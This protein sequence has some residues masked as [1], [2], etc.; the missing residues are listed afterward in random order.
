[1][2]KLFGQV[3]HVAELE[4]NPFA[5]GGQAILHRAISP[6]GFVGKIPT[7]PVQLEKARAVSC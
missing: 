3:Y 1:M 5:S 7:D 6:A 4:D 2:R